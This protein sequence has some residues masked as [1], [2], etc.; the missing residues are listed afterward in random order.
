[1]GRQAGLVTRGGVPMEHT[2]LYRLVYDRD[3]GG[4]SVERVLG[5]SLRYQLTQATNLR[6][7]SGAIRGVDGIAL[8]IL[9]VT[10]FSR[11]MVRHNFTCFLFLVPECPGEY[12]GRTSWD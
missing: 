11:S 1:M 10:L 4:E 9:Q 8:G 12:H 2:F 5:S 6:P 3:G 7:E